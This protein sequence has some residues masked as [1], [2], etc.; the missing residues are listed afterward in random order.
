M[1]LISVTLFG[2]SIVCNEVQFLNA[3]APIVSTLLPMVTLDKL[4][5]PWKTVDSIEVIPL[6]V[7]I[8]CKAEQPMKAE[9]P[10]LV[11]VS[12]IE[13]FVNEEQ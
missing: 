6:P 2:I 10:I 7:A 9:E 4:L 11:T 1:E 3:F 5:Q 8:V 12:G 13:T